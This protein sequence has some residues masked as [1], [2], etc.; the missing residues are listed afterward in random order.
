MRSITYW[1]LILLCTARWAK[2]E[3]FS[4]QLF[5]QVLQQHVDAR[6]RVDYETL[7]ESMNDSSA[8]LDAYI[9]SL[10]ALS[11]R[12][13]PERF[14][15]ERHE[16]AYWINAYN[17]FVIK[18]IVDAYPIGSVKDIMLFNGFFRRKKFTAGGQELTLDEIEKGIILPGYRDPRV[19]FVIN[20]GATS[21]PELENRAFSGEELDVRL[22]AAL[23]R[24]SRNPRHVRLDRANGRL[25]LSKIMDW[26]GKD[27]IRWFP[28]S[29]KPASRPP[30]LVDYLLPYLP[31]ETAA[32]LRD[33]PDV[34]TAF[35]DYD[36]SLNDRP[37]A[38]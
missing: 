31:A 18:G 36:W 10:A 28:E 19:H 32:Y 1:I 14:P 25:H 13:N 12:S 9:D 5:D 16:L 24:F 23:A 38:E 8:A 33:H 6:G 7:E 22:E 27:F 2:A 34:E 29:R 4:H 3:P 30:T 11:P 20:C 37:S 15:S 21:C 35:E 26:Y 17:A